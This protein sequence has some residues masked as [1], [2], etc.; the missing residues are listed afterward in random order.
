MACGFGA[1]PETP[2]EEDLQDDSAF[3]A[4]RPVGSSAPRGRAWQE[5]FVHDVSMS[6]EEAVVCSLRETSDSLPAA[7][8]ALDAQDGAEAAGDLLGGLSRSDSWMSMSVFSEGGTDISD[9]ATDC[10][11]PSSMPVWLRERVVS[12]GDDDPPLEFH[13]VER[14]GQ[15]ALIVARSLNGEVVAE[16]E[17]PE[18]DDELSDSSEVEIE[19]SPSGLAMAQFL[20]EALRQR[21]ASRTRTEG[22]DLAA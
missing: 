5:G 8:E 12:Q 7:A 18:S 19:R 10:S 20:S 14:V 4:Q 1:F 2:E 21:D 17:E 11:T 3:C 13:R 6:R 9:A 15:R 22:S 16:L